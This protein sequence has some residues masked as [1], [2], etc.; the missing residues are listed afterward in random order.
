M[1]PKFVT[2]FILR[3]IY[4]F[5]GENVFKIIGL[6]NDLEKGC[7][8]EFNSYRLDMVEAI[9]KFAVENI[10]YY[11][12]INMSISRDS[13]LG[14]FPVLTKSEIRIL[15]DR[16]FLPNISHS[17]RSTSGSTGSPFV[18]P[19]DRNASAHMDALMYYVY[20]WHGIKIGDRQARLWGTSLK[21]KAI[22]VQK[23][24][25]FL[26]NRRRLSAFLIDDYACKEYFYKLA[27]FAP[28]YFY[29]YSNALY[30]FA[31]SL[32]RQAIDGRQLKIPV[33]ICTGEILFPFQREKIESIFGCKVV[34]EYGSTE[35]GIIGFECEFG[36]L[37]VAP[38]IELEILNPDMDGYGHVVITELN[39]KAFP[40]IRYDIGD[41]ARYIDQQCCCGRPYRLIELKEGR[42]DDYIVCPDGSLVYDAILAYTLK[43]DVVKFRAVQEAIDLINI[44]IVPKLGFC[45][46]DEQRILS[47]LRSYLGHEMNI[48]F[49]LVNDI[50]PE[51]SGKLR[52][53]VSKFR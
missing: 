32:E 38:T 46:S 23:T 24:R 43:N 44:S 15:M 12:N 47:Q 52:Y 53:F 6:Y 2:N 7:I 13:A 31:L 5:R 35:N 8:E 40:F 21:S 14:V 45:L 17:W 9:C 30:Q 41:I 28:K 39:S 29:A 50:P 49:L 36:K 1:D 48:E 34:N 27:E 3:P 51:K 37:H 16:F 10:P 11:K 20:S 33:A 26:L 18:F 22:M 19:K 42:I 4:H 25:D